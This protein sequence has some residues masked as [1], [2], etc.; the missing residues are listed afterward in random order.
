GA[1]WTTVNATP[2]DPVQNM[3]G[4]WQQGGGEKD[5]NLLDFNEI[6]IDNKGRVLYGYSDGCVTPACIAGAAPNDFVANMRVA[7]Q[8][9]GKT[10]LASYD[11]NTDTTTALAPKPPC[12]S[13]T[14]DTSASHLTWKT[15]DNGGSAIVNYLIFRGTSSGNEVQ[16]GQ[17]GVPKN[18]FEDTSAD[19][20]VAHY[21]YEVK[22]VNTS[23][24]PVSNFSNEIDL[25]ISA[26]LLETPCSLPGLTILQDPTNDELDMVPAHDVQKL[27]IGEPFAFAS[28]K[29]VFTLK[30]QSL[31]TVPP[32][33]EWPIKFDA[34]DGNNYTVQMTTDPAD[35]ATVATPLFQVFKTSNGALMAPT[36]DPASNFT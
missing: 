15:P 24:T 8:S 3:T 17:T 33:T 28:D 26:A 2:N 13:G 16:I 21:F 22:A 18:S 36:A 14:R 12:L 7:R 32:S 25:P 20:N 29:I 4:I 19:P 9:G 35:G 34:P 10:L 11:G 23:G 31:A 5:R 1:N 27:S 30:V 6:T